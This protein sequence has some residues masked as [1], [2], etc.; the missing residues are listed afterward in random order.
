MS[1]VSIPETVTESLLR[2]TV[3]NIFEELD[4]SII[5]SYIE[6][7]DRVGSSSRKKV[8]IKMFRRKDA[9]RMRRVKK[10]LRV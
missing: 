5:P 9:H 4:A 10:P 7:C 3:L 8:I 2:E 6:A 1:R